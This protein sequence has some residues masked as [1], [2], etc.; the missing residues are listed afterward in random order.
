MM[1]R[2]QVEKLHDSL[3][4]R[5]SRCARFIRRHYVLLAILSKVYHVLTPRDSTTSYS[6]VLAAN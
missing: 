4:G 5:H 1:E 2:Q 6:C 3:E